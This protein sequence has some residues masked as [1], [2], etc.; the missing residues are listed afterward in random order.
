ML[1]SIV[2]HGITVTKGNNTE[3][4]MNT[5]VPEGQDN[6]AEISNSQEEIKIKG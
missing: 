1:S 5:D 3:V 2:N 4:K 6:N